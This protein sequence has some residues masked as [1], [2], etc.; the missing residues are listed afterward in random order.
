MVETALIFD[1][2]NLMYRA[3]HRFNSFTDVSGRPTSVIYGVPFVVEAQVRKFQPD[4]V[5]AVFDGARSKHRLKICPDYKGSRV[6]KLDFDKEDFLRQKEEVMEGLYNLGV[7]VVHNPDQEADDMIYSVV[8]LLQKQRVGTIIIISSDKDFNQLAT[9]KDVV[10]YNRSEE[11]RV[12]K[13]CRSRWSPY[14][15]Q[16]L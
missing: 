9:T 3:Y 11:R 4:L 5:I 13:E 15:L 16:T 12:G 10:I 2:N 1:A 6:Q 14:H 8:K 7:S